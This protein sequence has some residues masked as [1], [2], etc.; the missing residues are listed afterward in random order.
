MQSMAE[1]TVFIN[2]LYDESFELLLEA[3][4]YFQYSPTAQALPQAP[5]ARDRLFVNCQ[6]MRLA[7][8]MTQSMAW[9]LA[10]RALQNGEIS[11]NQ[12]CGGN[13]SLGA[14]SI[15]IDD[16]GHDDQRVPPSMQTLLKRSHSLYMRVLRL[17]QAARNKFGASDQ[18]A[19]R[20]H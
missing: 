8:R 11:P 15:C 20:P 7:S 18:Q 4:N 2:R 9:L 16:D 3:R 10:Q 14:E 12:A 17:D 6:A 5:T 19:A 13:Y 1:S